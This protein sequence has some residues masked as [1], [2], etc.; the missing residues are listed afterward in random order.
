LL[1]TDGDSAEAMVNETRLLDQQWD[2]FSVIHSSAW[3]VKLVA[4]EVHALSLKGLRRDVETLLKLLFGKSAFDEI[5]TLNGSSVT[6]FENG[7]ERTDQSSKNLVAHILDS[8][9]LSFAGSE[10]ESRGSLSGY[11]VTDL[12]SFLKLNDRG[13]YVY[14]VKAVYAFL[15]AEKRN[16]ESQGVI[17]GRQ[18]EDFQMEMRNT[19]YGLLRLNYNRE[20]YFSRRQLFSAWREVAEVSLSAGVLD[21][22]HPGSREQILSDIAELVLRKMADPNTEGDNVASLS[23]TFVIIVSRLRETEGIISDTVSSRGNVFGASRTKIPLDVIQSLIAKSLSCLESRGGLSFEF[24]GNLYTSTVYLL[25]TVLRDDLDEA[26][27]RFSGMLPESDKFLRIVAND[28]DSAE[29]WQLTAI[30]LLETLLTVPSDRQ[31]ILQVL[32]GWNYVRAFVRVLKPMDE[33]LCAY[34]GNDEYGS[35]SASSSFIYQQLMSLLLRLAVTPEGSRALLDSDFVEIVSMMRFVETRGEI[36]VSVDGLVPEAVER[37]HSLVMPLLRVLNGILA[38]NIEDRQVVQQCGAFVHRHSDFIISI[39][40]DRHPTVTLMS[41]RELEEVSTLLSNLSSNRELFGIETLYFLKV[42]GQA[43]VVLGDLLLGLVSKYGDSNTWESRLKPIDNV[44]MDRNGSFVGSG[45]STK[46]QTDGR[47]L[48]QKI[49]KNVLTFARRVVA[50][51]AQEGFF[52][53]LFAFTL[54]LPDAKSTTQEYHNVLSRTLLPS[55]GSLTLVLR[56][57]LSTLQYLSEEFIQLKVRM[58]EFE[59]GRSFD[60]TEISEIGCEIQEVDSVVRNPL[61]STQARQAV[62]LKGLEKMIA[63]RSG[64][65]DD[66]SC[67]SSDT[68]EHAL[69][70]IFRH[71]SFY[72]LEYVPSS[73]DNMDSRNSASSLLWPPPLPSATYTANTTTTKPTRSEL[74]R[75]VSNLNRPTAYADSSL[76]VILE[77]TKL[78]N[79]IIL[80]P[81]IS[82]GASAQ[83]PANLRYPQGDIAD[84]LYF[85]REA[86]SDTLS[87][88]LLSV[89][90]EL[91]DISK[92]NHALRERL[93]ITPEL[94]HNRVVATVS[95]LP[96]GYQLWKHY[97]TPKTRI[98]K[99]LAIDVAESLGASRDLEM[100]AAVD[101]AIRSG[102]KFSTELSFRG[103][104]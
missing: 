36:G 97:F 95:R 9:D 55:V 30:T 3:I 79:P 50:T 18:R 27:A 8:L 62:A 16:I 65:I 103:H 14:D 73:S 94:I 63:K 25:Q 81:P 89:G 11:G 78:K 15:V 12:S 10:A 74:Q 54:E 21:G 33:S 67:A 96:E 90:S 87:S 38:N 98:N 44:E 83:A 4:L 47:V 104:T 31:L 1:L 41:L 19:L 100:E 76:T 40:R 69:Y 52:L 39:L 66:A 75:M 7:M 6:F 72:F 26:D 32:S 43:K 35:E 51:M 85:Y 24:R 46:F 99:K 57:S 48:A 37:H 93:G 70:L 17:L 82:D 13:C 2:K 102:S 58:E 59:G 23:A 20:D 64:D 34:I 84:G 60:P 91:L 101:N 22:L 29:S 92:T 45:R 49:V 5:E 86:D 61:A 80:A 68:I 53:P 42:P 56:S 28:S 77:D 88:F 71:L